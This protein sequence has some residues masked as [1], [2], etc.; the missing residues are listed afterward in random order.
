M[1]SVQVL[2]DQKTALEAEIARTLKAAEDRKKTL[3]AQIAKQ[4]A[5]EIIEGRAAI[6]KLMEQ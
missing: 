3:E 5:E 6:R 4:R 2:I 1:P